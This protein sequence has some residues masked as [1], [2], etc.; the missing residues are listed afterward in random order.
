MEGNVL[1]DDLALE[2]GEFAGAGLFGDLLDVVEVLEDFV[3]G[4]EGLLEDVVDAD[5]ALDGLEQHEQGEDEAGEIGRR[6][7]APALIWSRA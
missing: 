4:A 2:G 6:R 3:R 5:Q 1:E 7:M